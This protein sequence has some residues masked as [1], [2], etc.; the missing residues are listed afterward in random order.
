[1]ENEC[2]LSTIDNPFNPFE[3]FVSWFL[4]DE[5]KGHKSCSLLD[6]F[7]KTNDQMSEKEVNDEI[8]RAIDEIIKYDFENKRIK[9]RK[10]NQN[11]T[12]TE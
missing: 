10:N 9:V 5:E 8:E 12:K 6:R 4:Y 7:A 1:M 2:M 11:Q 3:Q